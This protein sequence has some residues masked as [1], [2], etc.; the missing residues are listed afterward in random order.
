[1]R[2]PICHSNCALADG[3]LQDLHFKSPVLLEGREH[4]T[5]ANVNHFKKARLLQIHD[6]FSNEFTVLG[7]DRQCVVLVASLY[8][9]SACDTRQT[10]LR[11]LL[12]HKAIGLDA[13]PHDYIVNVLVRCMVHN[14]SNA[15]VVQSVPVKHLS[16]VNKRFA[17][18]PPLSPEC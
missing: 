7:Q 14:F 6:I 10:R 12:C 15:L 2:C 9:A 5:C 18:Q 13:G 11:R 17:T 4:L 16:N 8:V 1:M 3:G